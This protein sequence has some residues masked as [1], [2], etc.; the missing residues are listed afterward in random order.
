[1]CEVLRSSREIDPIRSI[2]SKP[3]NFD[4]VDDKVQIRQ[5]R[6]C[7]GKMLSESEVRQPFG[8]YILLKISL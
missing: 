3:P 2:N 4:L 5:I 7:D 1:M 8:D 6:N